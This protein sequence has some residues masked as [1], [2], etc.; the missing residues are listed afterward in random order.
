MELRE[1][2]HQARARCQ[3][4]CAEVNLGSLK[5]GDRRGKLSR[6]MLQPHQFRNTRQQHLQ[7]QRASRRTC[8]SPAPRVPSDVRHG[9]GLVR[10]G[11]ISRA[12]FHFFVYARTH[13]GCG[14]SCS[15]RSFAATRPPRD[16]G[17]QR[18]FLKSFFS[19]LRARYMYRVS[20][21]THDPYY[22][23]ID[24]AVCVTYTYR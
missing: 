22:G 3:V 24:S 21:T 13:A 1:A 11:N 8:S 12:G 17:S 19:M 6:V 14:G 4:F 23:G 18:E 2:P 20:Y 5:R 10:A 16:R 15:C 7:R 9:C